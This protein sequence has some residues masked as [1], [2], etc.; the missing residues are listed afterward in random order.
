[1]DGEM[2]RISSS[3][4]HSL[5]VMEGPRNRDYNSWGGW[6]SRGLTAKVPPQSDN[7]PQSLLPP[8][9][10]ITTF[11]DRP[12]SQPASDVPAFPTIGDFLS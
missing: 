10:F 6:L 8:H 12:A 11:L 4:H 3:L 7:N 1:M 5:Q 2:T 9:P